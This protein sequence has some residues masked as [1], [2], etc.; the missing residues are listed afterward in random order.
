MGLKFDK[1]KENK[2]IYTAFGNGLLSQIS[3]NI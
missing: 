1:L 3:K 2:K